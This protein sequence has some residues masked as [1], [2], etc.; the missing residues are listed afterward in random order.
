MPAHHVAQE[1]DAP[2]QVITVQ[3]DGHVTAFGEKLGD[4]LW[5]TALSSLPTANDGFDLPED[6]GIRHAELVTLESAS[7]GIL[8]GRQDVLASLDQ[9]DA[10]WTCILTVLGTSPSVRHADVSDV[11]LHVYALRSSLGRN[12]PLSKPQQLLSWNLPQVVK[13]KTS[14]SLSHHLDSKSGS[15]TELV[16]GKIVSFSLKGLSPKV[17][18]TFT[19]REK[20]GSVLQLSSSILLSAST[21]QIAVFDSKYGSQLATHGLPPPSNVK[22]GK[23]KSEEIQTPPLAFID[24]FKR[25]GQVVA[26]RGAELLVIQT[27]EL[28]RTTKRKRAGTLLIDSIGKGKFDSR[29][30]STAHREEG[31]KKQ[32]KTKIGTSALF[33]APELDALFEQEK[34]NEFEDKFAA[35]V[36]F[37]IARPPKKEEAAEGTPKP[38]EM[39]HNQWNFP[40]PA[41]LHRRP[42]QR[43]HALYAI[44]K[45]FSPMTAEDGDNS[46]MNSN[47]P[48]FQLN[49]AAENI[50]LWLVQTGQLRADI[51]QRALNEYHG[52]N[53]HVE[54]G[55][56]VQALYNFADD[57]AWVNYVI[58]NH[59]DLHVA[60]IVTAIKLII[61]NLDEDKLPQPEHKLLMD[62]EF[63]TAAASTGA[64]T[65]GVGLNF[66]LPTLGIPQVDGSPFSRPAVDGAVDA[67]KVEAEVNETRDSE[68][69]EKDMES[70]TDSAMME[71]DAMIDEAY[72]NLDNPPIR[73]ETLRQAF[74]RLNA[75]PLNQVTRALRDK[76]THHELI[77]LIHILRLELEQGGWTTRF[78]DREEDDEFEPSSSA[79]TVVAN[80]LN[81]AVDAV[82]MSGW[83]T[84]SSAAPIDNIDA[85]LTDLRGEISNTLEG[86]HESTFIAG[87]LAEFLRY[88]HR[89]DLDPSKLSAT[90]RKATNAEQDEKAWK[91]GQTVVVEDE[92]SPQLPMGLVTDEAHGVRT[93]VGGGSI[94]KEL[95]GVTRRRTAA[96]VGREIR[97]ALPPYVF[98]RIRF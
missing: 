37:S 71:V 14:Q 91:R 1:E 25:A 93:T 64:L 5:S 83:L 34:F 44:S 95:N 77:F 87:V 40:K 41:K 23:S 33:T 2:F 96:D 20:L 16:D 88:Y 89:L 59:T 32:K 38:A 98:E 92:P 7:Q 60:E 54:Q 12:A 72:E 85:T 31:R 55:D 68:A 30:R 13:R 24:Y 35:V 57:L 74:T 97:R 61:N 46:G 8:N 80:I 58:E 27:S 53:G 78:G 94:V 3:Q 82:G 81:C 47:G 28:V 65:G 48:S 4:P 45:L 11:D 9:A 52:F 36:G 69:S 66:K 56:V 79:I 18:D 86:V 76:L 49:L 39:S 10:S 42:A 70:V 17:V 6:F 43:S 75:L 22:K 73:G 84:T 63:A 21:E 50:F 67:G 90:T 19:S 51:I 26:F 62:N 15:L 29:L